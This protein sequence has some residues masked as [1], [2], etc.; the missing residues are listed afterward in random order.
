MNTRKRRSDRSGRMPLFCPGRPPVAGRDERRRFWRAI[1]AGMASEDAAVEVGI[2]QAVGTRWFREAGGMPGSKFRL[3]AK[4]LCSRYLSFAE[5]EE[6]AL[7]RVKGCSIQPK[8][9]SWLGGWSAGIGA[10]NN[11]PLRHAAVKLNGGGRNCR[12]RRNFFIASL[13][14]RYSRCSGLNCSAVERSPSKKAAI[15]R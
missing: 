14:M 13:R 15:R 6:I 8:N 9:G 5:R 3:S 1:A 10:V 2:S 11:R 7:L 4:P 12:P